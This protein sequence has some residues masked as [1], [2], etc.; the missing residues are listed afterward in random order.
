MNAVC[1][2]T[3][4]CF[5]YHDAYPNPGC[6]ER[7]GGPVALRERLRHVHKQI[8]DDYHDHNPFVKRIK[9]YVDGNG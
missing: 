8:M 2:D 1:R 9:Q 3:N 5:A 4:K 7:C 6:G